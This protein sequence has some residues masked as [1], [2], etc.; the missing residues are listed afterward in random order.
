MLGE[1]ASK[2]TRCS[3]H[4][5]SSTPSV[6]SFEPPKS[7]YFYSEYFC[8]WFIF[9]LQ[10]TCFIHACLVILNKLSISQ[11]KDPHLCLCPPLGWP[12]HT[13]SKYN[14]PQLKCNVHGAAA[15][16]KVCDDHKVLIIY[17]IWETFLVAFKIIFHMFGFLLIIFY[18]YQETP[19]TGNFL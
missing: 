10:C 4:M 9:V 2:N 3:T 14:T 1:V 5:N 15:L 17:C 18:C 19:W 16:P 7:P 8:T 13:W 12:W 11:M 6:S